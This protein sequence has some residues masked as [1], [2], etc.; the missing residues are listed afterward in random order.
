MEQKN[1]YLKAPNA[2][3]GKILSALLNCNRDCLDSIIEELIRKNQI[4]FTI[5]GTKRWTLKIDGD[6]IFGSSSVK[7]SLRKDGY[8]SI[9]EAVE[10][11]REKYDTYREKE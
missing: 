4:V 10:E 8:R 7:V 2:S 9:A 1:Y 6:P 5:L 11:I 3:A